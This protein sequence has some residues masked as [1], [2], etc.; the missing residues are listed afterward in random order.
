MCAA[1]LEVYHRYMCATS[2]VVLVTVY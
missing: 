2:Y 1:K